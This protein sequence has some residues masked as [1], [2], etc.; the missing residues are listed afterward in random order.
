MK[1]ANTLC[2]IQPICDIKQQG[3]AAW[4]SVKHP[5]TSQAEQASCNWNS[6]NYAEC[7]ALD[8]CLCIQKL[9]SF[10]T[11]ALI[12][13]HNLSHFNS[14]YDLFWS[15]TKFCLCPN[16]TTTITEALSHLK[17]QSANLNGVDY[18]RYLNV[19]HDERQQQMVESM[20]ASVAAGMQQSEN[21]VL[22]ENFY[23]ENSHSQNFWLCRGH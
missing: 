18:Y 1:N 23:Q 16:L 2:E 4:I 6:I 11:G 9:S 7:F 19:E 14:N 3:T 13:V 10:S 22:T 20:W 17:V 5:H 15:V 21:K 8:R 12:H